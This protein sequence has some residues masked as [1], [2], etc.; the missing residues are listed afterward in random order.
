MSDDL[1]ASTP[2]PSPSPSEGAERSPGAY[3]E[4]QNRGSCG[5]GATWGGK[6]LEHCTACHRTFTGTGPGDKHR[7]GSHADPA[8]PRRCL[9][10]EEMTAKG[11]R[12]N[13]HG[14]WTGGGGFWGDQEATA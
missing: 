2:L 4:G 3:G 5:C 10:V 11:M 9:S 13:Q 1:R 6:R 8:D 14:H 7:V 12:P